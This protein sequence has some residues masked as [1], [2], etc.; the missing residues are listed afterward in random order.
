MPSPGIVHVDAQVTVGS[1][2]VT[3]SRIAFDASVAQTTGMDEDQ[4]S[5]VT[6][7]GLLLLVPS[8]RVR[9]AVADARLPGDT[10]A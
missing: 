10:G 5:R 2:V 4:A 9:D 7:P 6:L 3:R 8:G 1:S